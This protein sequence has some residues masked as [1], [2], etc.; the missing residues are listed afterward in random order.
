[1]PIILQNAM[2]FVLYLHLSAVGSRSLFQVS[3]FVLFEFGLGCVID[4]S[5]LRNLVFFRSHFFSLSI[6]KI[7]IICNACLF[8]Y[9]AFTVS[10]KVGM[11]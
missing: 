2:V 6:T 3:L 10:G 5:I 8:D 7:K 4:S 9:T 11:P 1:M